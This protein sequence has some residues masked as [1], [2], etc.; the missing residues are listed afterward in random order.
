MLI[1]TEDGGLVAG[2]ATD[3]EGAVSWLEEIAN[4]VRGRFGYVTFEER[5]PA[6]LSDFLPR[7]RTSIGTRLVEGQILE[8]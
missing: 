4:I 5:P 6:L 7:C 1:F 8:D 2:I 3:A